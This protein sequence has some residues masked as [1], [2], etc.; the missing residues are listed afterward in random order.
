[1]AIDQQPFPMNALDLEGKK[2]L[3]RPERAGSANKANVVVGEPRNTQAGNMV[4]GRKATI[5]REP[6][7]KEVIKITISNPTLGG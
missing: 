7:G 3:I 1:M 2:I 4:T 5:S 6:S